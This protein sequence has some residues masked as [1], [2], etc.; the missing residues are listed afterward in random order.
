MEDDLMDEQCRMAEE[1]M[2]KKPKVNKKGGYFDSA[3]YELQKK[4][5]AQESEGSDKEK[6]EK[7]VEKK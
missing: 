6:E 5:K 3:N 4:K 7:E 2:K 1:L